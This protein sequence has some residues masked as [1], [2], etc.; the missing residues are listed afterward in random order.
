MV[1]VERVLPTKIL[2]WIKSPNLAIGFHVFRVS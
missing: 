1:P 2:I